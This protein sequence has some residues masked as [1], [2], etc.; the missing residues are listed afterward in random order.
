[1]NRFLPLL[2]LITLSA[3]FFI[4]AG[5]KVIERYK[6]A[7]LGKLETSNLNYKELLPT[8]VEIP[9]QEILLP[10]NLAR[11]E[12]GEWKFDGEGAFYLTQSPI[13]GDKG[14]SIIFGH[15]FP[16]AFGKLANTK[17]GDII[18]V[19][20]NDGSTKEFEV[21]YKLNVTPDQ[22]HILE[23]TD[24]TRISIYTCSGFLDLKRL[25]V[26]ATPKV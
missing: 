7:P 19:S 20:F 8:S 25:V 10:I 4:Q 6:V 21:E 24:D 12:D 23:Q 11:V 1:M 3:Y 22:T 5:E 17:T 13:P 26:V 9:S 14:N 2:I 16:T 18:K 15:N